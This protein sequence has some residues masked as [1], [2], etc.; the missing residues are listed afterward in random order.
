MDIAPATQ[1]LTTEGA[2]HDAS[3]ASGGATKIGSDFETFLRMLTAQVRNQDPLNPIDATDYATQLATFS[4]VE[5]QV[6][7]NDLLRGLGDRLGQG[8]IQS[9]TSWLDAEVLTDDAVLFDGAPI[10]LEL[11]HPLPPGAPALMVTDATGA[12]VSLES[13]PAN[14]GRI[15]WA[16]S[17]SNG[18]PL[19]RGA[20]T[21]SLVSTDDAGESQTLPVAAYDTVVEATRNLH[22][23]V[24]LRLAGGAELSAET[25]QAVRVA[26]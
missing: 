22:G 8:S 24:Q 1:A 17:D 19:P 12:A 13:L 9:L 14:G 26:R 21:F 18:R 6:L 16:G 10:D 15:S 3:G 23:H 25:A 5:Q 2:S 7:T 11:P 20:Y 4:S